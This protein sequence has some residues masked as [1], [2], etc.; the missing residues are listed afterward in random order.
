MASGFWRKLWSYGSW[1]YNYLCNQCISPLMLWVRISIRAKR[2]TLC[3]KVCQWLVT[4]WWFSPGSS[5]SSTNKCD[6][7]DLIEIVLKVAL[8]TINQT[9]KLTGSR[10]PNYNVFTMWQNS[11]ELSFLSLC[12]FNIMCLIHWNIKCGSVSEN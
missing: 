9:S 6:R 1:I 5:V 3:N 10:L 12:S 8:N 11:L 7:H 2:T 4:G